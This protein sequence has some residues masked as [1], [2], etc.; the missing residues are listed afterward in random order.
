MR[1][2]WELWQWLSPVGIAGTISLKHYLLLYGG[3]FLIWI[4]L[5][6]I[7]ATIWG[8]GFFIFGWVFFIFALGGFDSVG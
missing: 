8:V 2:K 6:I 4:L 1:W 3:F 5:D 7:L